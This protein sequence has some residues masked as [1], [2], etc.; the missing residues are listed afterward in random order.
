ML[1]EYDLECPYCGNFNDIE[2]FK[3]NL[4]SEYLLGSYHGEYDTCFHETCEVC[5][6]DFIVN[7]TLKL[8]PNFTITK[9]SKIED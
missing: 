9:I 3:N 7:L 1:N 6:K 8:E 5:E 4:E 2:T